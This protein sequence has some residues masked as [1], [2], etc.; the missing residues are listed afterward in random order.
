[1][2][3]KQSGPSQEPL[4]DSEATKQ[5]RLEAEFVKR[6]RLVCLALE[7]EVNDYVRN[8]VQPQLDKDWH[9]IRSNSR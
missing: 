1:M 8:L 5:V 6:L 4:G 3:K 7:I 9:E 2:A